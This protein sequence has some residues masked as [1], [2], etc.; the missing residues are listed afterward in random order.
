MLAGACW[1]LV[2]N[3]WQFSVLCYTTWPFGTVAQ[4]FTFFSGIRWFV[5]SLSSVH[6]FACWQLP[7]DLHLF[8][9]LHETIAWWYI[10][11]LTVFLSVALWTVF[12]QQLLVLE[13]AM[14][15]AQ[16]HAPGFCVCICLC[17]MLIT[18]FFNYSKNATS[19]T[20]TTHIKVYEYT[21]AN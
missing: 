4:W 2:S 5:D 6:S 18:M 8:T 9:V 11:L 21:K 14:T 19:A 15:Q 10:C 12:Q 17:Q 13:S 3:N 7:D 16:S 1:Q 20:N